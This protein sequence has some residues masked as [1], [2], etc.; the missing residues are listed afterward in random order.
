MFYFITIGWI[1]GV[2]CMGQKFSFFPPLSNISLIF[3]LMLLMG[4]IYIH[5]RIHSYLFKFINLV[6]ACLFSILLGFNYADE[7]LEQRLNLRESQ[8]DQVEVL[9]YVQ[10]LSQLREKGIQQK[11]EVLSRHAKPVTWFTYLAQDKVLPLEL[12]KY[13]R[14]TG[15][16]RPAHGY[17]TSGSFDLE[18]WYIQQNIMGSLSV[19]AVEE[20][21][22]TQVQ[23]SG[24]FS[25][26]KKQQSLLNQSLL[27]IEKQ[28][29]EI[30]D[31]I[32]QQPIRHKGLSLALLTGDESLLDKD[33]EQQFQHFG[34]SHLLA[35][36][37]PHVVIFALM[38]CWIIQ[39]LIHHFKPSMYLKIPKQY[40][41][42]W[43]FL[44]CVI[45]Y[46]AYVGFEIP[47]MR[48]LLICVIGSLCILFKQQVKPLV[49]LLMSAFLLLLFDPFS[50]LSAAFWLSYGACFIL[51]RIYQT[52]QNENLENVTTRQKIKQYLWVLVESQWKI[53]IALFPLMI[54]FFKQIAWITPLSNLFAIPWIGLVIVP[55]DIMAGSAY[56][57]FEP[58]S[59]ALFQI[60]DLMLSILIAFINVLDQLFSPQLYP[61]YFNEWLLCGL[62]I[63]IIIVFMPKG[64]L[65]L[66]WSVICLIPLFLGGSNQAPFEM[67][68]LDVGQG[69]SIFIRNLNKNMMI[70]TGGHYNEDEFSIGHQVTLP[71]LSVQNA[72]QLDIMLLSHLDQDHS[73]AYF[74]I[75]DQ[76]K[77]KKLY[78]NEIVEGTQSTQLCH[79]GQN[80]DLGEG[81]E[82]KILSPKQENLVQA[83][84]DKN[85]ASCV[86]YIQLQNAYPY[87]NYL[88]MGDAGWETEFNILEQYP[89]LKVDVLVLGHHGSQ[90]SSAYDFLQKINPKLAIISAGFDNR[91][92]HPS[93]KTIQRL[94]Q[95]NIPYL[96]TAKVG[97]VY[98]QVKN[99]G[100]VQ[101]MTYREQLKWL[102]DKN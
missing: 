68:V 97:S 40:L 52:I 35:I 19:N 26:V 16:I 6:I 42:I 3:I 36:S 74:K 5:L 49:L 46:S 51:L 43:P 61:M 37:G 29:L 48:T 84:Y 23:G 87:Q 88:V 58:L 60:N 8:I 70:D 39:R 12:G 17:A 38:V 4:Q 85:E 53:F 76:L 79:Q 94:E 63:A 71:F 91:Y 2:A 25:Y 67:V 56:F 14:L 31:F 75:R 24:Y 9:V 7:K 62:L 50:V 32:Q 13:Y 15:K 92:G 69:Q 65:P 1:F 64:I 100:Q 45:I 41:L 80:L 55:L 59:R 82:I 20:I 81:I 18:K 89:D 95:L 102:E 22:E 98:I 27:W 30:R 90:H 10:E 34:M 33:L 57:I 47:A 54:I 86:V 96:S 73:G 21:S 78:A 99:N 11:V 66:S 83:Q 44:C 28:R 93:I 101:L 72:R 77:I